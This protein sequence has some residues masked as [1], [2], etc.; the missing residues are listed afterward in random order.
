MFETIQSYTEGASP[1]EHL[2][3]ILE[4]VLLS[5]SYEN[6]EML[7]SILRAETSEFHHEGEK[8][9]TARN[10]GIDPGQRKP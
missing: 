6:E 1:I 2:R 10:L 8:W 7:F 9:R 3:F 4:S 5:K